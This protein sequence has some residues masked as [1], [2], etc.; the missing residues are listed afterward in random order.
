MDVRVSQKVNSQESL[1]EQGVLGM[2]RITYETYSVCVQA[3]RVKFL[4]FVSQQM[5]MDV[6]TGYMAYL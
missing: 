1:A 6:V 5:L 3:V 2:F 4:V